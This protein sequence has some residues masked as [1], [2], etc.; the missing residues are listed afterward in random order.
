MGQ[1]LGRPRW[2][3]LDALRGFTL[4]SMIVYHGCWDLVWI[5]GVD[6]AWYRSRGAFLWQQSICWTFILLS[7]FCW[8][9]G[10]RPV[11]RGLEVF[12]AGALVSAVTLLVLPEDRILWGV[13]TLLGASMVLLALL[14]P[15]L[16]RVPAAA[17]EIVCFLLFL[18]LRRIGSGTLGLGP[19]QISLPR[20]LY[21]DLFT[22]FLGFPPPG[23]YSTDYFPL[24]PWGLLFLTGYF[25]YR[26][27]EERGRS[28]SSAGEVPV[29][30]WLGRRSLP[31]YLLHQPLLYG[32]LSALRAL[33]AI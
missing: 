25:L 9:L 29:L 32:L 16:R 18:A 12:A 6:W 13:L 14:E 27:W 28:P 7:G 23:F 11:R 22:A 17:G 19:L 21:R 4:L 5:F 15:L 33:G 3:S 24:L 30:G 31:V 8:S 20:G 1:E 2:A 10:R 26:I